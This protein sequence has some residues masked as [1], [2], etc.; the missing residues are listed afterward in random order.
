M[1]CDKVLQQPALAQD[2]RFK[3]NALRIA[4]NSAP[5]D[6]SLTRASSG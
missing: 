1:F 3:G 5:N 4:Y 2:A 6:G